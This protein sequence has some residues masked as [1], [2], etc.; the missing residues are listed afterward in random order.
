ML[1]AGAARRWRASHHPFDAALRREL[2]ALNAPAENEIDRCARAS[3]TS[4]RGATPRRSTALLRASG[5]TAAEVRAIGC[6]GQTVR[7]R[8]DRGYT[9]QIGNAALLAERTGIAVVADFRRRD[10]AAGGQGA[11]LAPAFH[12][13]LFRHRSENRAVVNIGGIANVTGCPEGTVARL[14]LR[15]RQLPARPVGRRASRRALRRRR[16]VGRGRTVD[17]GPARAAAAT[18]RSSPRRRRRAPGATCSTKPGSMRGL[19]RR[20]SRAR[21]AGDA[22]RADRA[23]V[24]MRSTRCRR[25]RAPGHRL[26]RRCAATSRSMRRIAALARRRAGRN[27]AT[28]MGVDPSLRGSRRLRLAR[29]AQRSTARPA[30]SPR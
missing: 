19:R 11:P 3:A 9:L 21:R 18:S 15:A 30:T 12:A 2:L 7:H 29:R 24:A 27:R 25:G 17:P 4:W 13:A 6:H 28:R 14:R 20:A 5:R 23:H 8:P 16:R 1:A 22:A 10:I 26:R